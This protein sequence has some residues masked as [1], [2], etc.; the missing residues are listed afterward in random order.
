MDDGDSWCFDTE[1][2]ARYQ[3]NSSAFPDGSLFSQGFLSE[4]SE[5]PTTPCESDNSGELERSLDEALA[6]DDDDPIPGLSLEQDQLETPD[7]EGSA[8]HKAAPPV[9]PR[10]VATD[11]PSNHEPQHAPRVN[12]VAFDIWMRQKRA[13]TLRFP[14]ERNVAAKVFGYK[15]LRSLDLP[16]IGC[17]VA[18]AASATSSEV[19]TPTLD[20]SFAKKRLRLSSMIQSED[21]VRWE[22]LRK[23]KVMLTINPGNSF[24]GSTLAEKALLLRHE[25]EISSSFSDAFSGKSTGT[26]T[27]RASSCWRFVTWTIQQGHVDPLAVGEPVFYA[28]MNHLRDHGAPTTATTFIESWTFLFHMAGLKTQPLGMVLSPRVRGAAKDMYASKRK[29]VQAVPLTVKMVLALEQ[30]VQIA[31][32]DHWKIIAGHLLFCFGASSRFSD[33]L[34]LD[35][36]IL[37]KDDK[38]GL[39]LV[40]A[41]TGRYKTGNTNERRTRLL[42]LLSLGHFFSGQPWAETWIELRSKYKLPTSPSLPAFSEVTNEWLHRPMSTGEACLYLQEIMT[43]SGFDFVDAQKLGCHSLK[44]TMLSWLAMGSYAGISDRRLAG[45]HLDPNNVSPVTYSRDELTR[46]LAIEQRMI[47]DIRKKKFKPDQPRV[48]RLADLIAA[49]CDLDEHPHVMVESDSGDDDPVETDLQIDDLPDQARVNFD[50][51][52][53]NAVRN[54]RIHRYSGVGHILDTDSKFRCG[55]KVTRNYHDIVAGTTLADIPICLQC[56]KHSE[57]DV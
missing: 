10:Q 50:D 5:N 24:L 52:T 11:V 34:H 12:E 13:C 23:F 26:L 9:G 18:L 48:Q 33:S 15:E 6:A 14:W 44:C 16:Q 57:Q 37:S 51:L 41:D 27:K 7:L 28:Y 55:R 22:A 30:A 38:S 20:S 39:L 54:C 4:R 43:G 2:S 29:L 42:P 1:S 8:S 45:H 31:P 36:L 35:S 49:E 47:R 17:N 40:E 46:V 56:T 19:E 32:Y 3:V 21:Q 25:A 53:L